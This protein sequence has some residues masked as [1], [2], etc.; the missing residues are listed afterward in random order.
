MKSTTLAVEFE[1]S[2]CTNSDAEHRSLWISLLQLDSSII[3]HRELLW[4]RHPSSWKPK[5]LPL[6]K[7]FDGSVNFEILHVIFY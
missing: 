4:N 1:V 6:G 2:T 7:S 3:I 5:A